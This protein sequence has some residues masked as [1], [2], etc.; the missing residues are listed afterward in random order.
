[1]LDFSGK[2]VLVTGSTTGIGRGAAEMFLEAG[3]TVAING[4]KA[5]AVEEAVREMG[6]KRLVAAPGDVGTIAGCRSII[7]GAVAQ[8]GGLDVL[9]NNAGI[10]PLAYPLDV[11]EEHWDQVMAVNL[12]A[13]LFL[14][15]CALPHL[16]KSRG[17]VVMVASAAGL[18]AGPTDSFVYAVS[19]GGLVNLTRTLA[20]EL[21]PE[22][23]RINA[24]CP[25]YI[26]TPMVRAENEATHG[27][28]YEFINRSVPM[29]R[30]GTVREC[31][32]SIL[33]LAAAEAGYCTG[34]VLVNDGGCFANGS[35]GGA[36]VSPP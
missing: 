25:G 31:A 14:T 28:V 5:S 19:K 6:G 2:R 12:T 21:A 4:R 34:A 7:Q 35:W 13:P 33:Y 30:I 20:V 3:A 23:I 16:R 18:F 9:V 11:T 22:G 36:N 17:N 27:Q 10:C 1:M 26:D 8:L 24:I 29:E 15:I 32:S